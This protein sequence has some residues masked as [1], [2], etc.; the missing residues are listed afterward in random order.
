MQNGTKALYRQTW[1]EVDLGAI[2]WNVSRFRQWIPQE[3]Q[4]MAVVKADG[5][6]HGA[7]PV[8]R[9][10]EQAGATWL[11]VALLEEALELRAAGITL[12]ILVFGHIPGAFFPLA[13]EQ[14]ISVSIN[15]FEDWANALQHVDPS[16]PPLRFHLKLDTGMSRLGLLGIEELERFISAYRQTAHPQLI[17]EGLYTHFATAD[18]EDETYLQKQW[19]QFQRALDLLRS[20]RLTVPFAHAENSAGIVR[21]HHHL[22]TNLVRLGISMY[23]LYPSQTIERR[24][25]FPLKQ[26][27]SLHSRLSM[28]KRMREGVGVSYGATYRT[29]EEEWVGTIPIGYADGWRRALSNQAEVLISGRRQPLI[30]RICM[31]QCLV[32]LEGEES[33]GEKVTL[34]GRQ[35]GEEISI[36]ELAATLETINYEIPCMITARVPRLYLS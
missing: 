19:Q 18:E 24:S 32:R 23:G 12:P 9:A 22:N 31:D 16:L 28:V 11:A 15:H 21:L 7:V 6:G 3:K 29:R 17:W 36:D 20:S 14:Q 30:G 10:A 5:Y 25:P 34:I 8:A 33:V 2:R 1:A 35:A 4:L 27:F 13:Q 26:A